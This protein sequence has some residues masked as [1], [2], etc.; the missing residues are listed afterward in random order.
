MEEE[1]EE[2]EKE[3]SE[4]ESPEESVPDIMR[5]C[6]LSRHRLGSIRLNGHLAVQNNILWFF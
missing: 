6:Q 1:D 2:M 5:Q 4:R 3:V